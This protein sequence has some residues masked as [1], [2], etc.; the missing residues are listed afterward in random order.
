MLGDNR[1]G[2]LGSVLELANQI[3]RTVDSY[4]M[5]PPSTTWQE[6]RASLVKIMD[7]VNKAEAE[8]IQTGV[9]ERR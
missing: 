4:L 1:E 8:A 9:G 6:V 5:C 2:K 3:A 7:V